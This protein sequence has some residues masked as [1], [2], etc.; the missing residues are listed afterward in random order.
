MIELTHPVI[1]QL[2]IAALTVGSVY[3]VVN[4]KLGNLEKSFDSFKKE[5]EK[6]L[7]ESEQRQ[8][9]FNSLM[10]GHI[11]EDIIRLE[12]KQDKHNNLIERVTT[13]ERSADKA[14]RRLDSFATKHT[15]LED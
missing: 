14:H 3:G 12:L 9:E 10:V 15:K 7:K 4:T 13:V 5:T 1:I 2:I 8:A 6:D 11:K